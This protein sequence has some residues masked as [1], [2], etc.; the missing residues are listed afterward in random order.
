MT[1]LGN[2]TVVSYILKHKLS[3]GKKHELM[4]LF[5]ICELSLAIT[6]S[7]VGVLLQP[8]REKIDGKTVTHQVNCF[9]IRTKEMGYTI[10]NMSYYLPLTTNP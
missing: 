9:C 3:V 4:L 5:H 2:K 7:E 1:N 10:K 6:Y 8:I